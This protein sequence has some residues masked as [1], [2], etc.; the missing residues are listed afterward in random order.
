MAIHTADRPAQVPSNNNEFWTPLK[1]GVVIGAAAVS[2]L[3]IGAKVGHD[4]IATP[5]PVETSQDTDAPATTYAPADL[6][7]D[8]R[9]SELEEIRADGTVTK[10]ELNSLS[11]PTQTEFIDPADL[12]TAYAE[13]F[14]NW[15]QQTIDILDKKG[16]L[17]AEQKAVIAEMPNTLI[18]KDEWSDQM[19]VNAISLDIADSMIQEPQ[20]LGVRMLPTVL[21]PE[22]PSFNEVRGDIGKYVTLNIL[23][24]DVSR[25]P[26][27][28]EFM[29]IT[30]LTPNARVIAADHVI[31]DSATGDV[32]HPHVITLVDLQSG[33]DGTSQTWR[34][35]GSWNAYDP[36]ARA[37]FQELVA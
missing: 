8:G 28:G 17:T 15:R 10:D 14:D 6:N 22:A 13:D 33:E 37:A 25:K 19:V 5:K 7:H 18:P 20:D 12:A 21:D 31:N 36:S 27:T 30:E 1:K 35:L 2:L 29:G 16:W 26:Q 11:D 34:E 4:A 24:T 9:I 3:G 23:K 32:D